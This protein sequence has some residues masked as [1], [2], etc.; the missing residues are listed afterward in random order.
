[1]WTQ[2]D[3][4]QAYQFLRRR[5][6]S[7]LVKADANHP[8]SPSRR[9]VLGTVVGF[10]A[11]L[12]VTAVFGILGVLN[13]N[14][15][16]TWQ[17]GGY[18][19]VEQET[20]ERLVV[21]QDK[22]LHPTLNYTSARLYAGGKGDK[23]VT[24]AAADLA[25][26][27][28]GVTVG[29]PGAPDSIPAANRLYGGGWL[30]CS[31]LPADQPTGA[32]P[33]STV[34]LVA[35]GGDAAALPANR[36]LL[37]AL[38]DGD[39]FLI[40][41]G[42]R[43]RITTAALIA[44]GYQDA[45]PITVAP[46]WVNTVPAGADFDVIGVPGAGAAG[47]RVGDQNTRVGQVLMV[48]T[49]TGSSAYY[50]V[51]SGGLQPIGPVEAAL[52]LADPANGGGQHQQAQSASA[53]DVATAAQVAAANLGAGGYPDVVPSMSGPSGGAQTV[54][55]VND[56]TDT[57]SRTSILLASSVPLPS[58]ST[59][60]SRPVPDGTLIADQVYVPS[61]SGAL[62]RARN[63][64]DPASGTVYLVTDSGMKYPVAG[65]TEL[66]ALGYG[67]APVRGMAEGLLDL[68]PTGPELDA[69]ASHQIVSGGA[70]R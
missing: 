60:I 34:A 33:R 4:I 39:R 27:S 42:Y 46:D 53:T 36:A 19:I 1:V 23:T 51:R 22:M 32:A 8:T 6:V 59:P 28:R 25:G 48:S 58:G 16:N 26:M 21:G 57:G 9:L 17:Q 70:A 67:S 24:V 63:L 2:R 44:L 37:V 12:L 29:I 56:S 61:S 52:I 11:T 20:G 62:V 43:H 18:V 47:T 55:S 45:S 15:G 66:A 3:Q 10:A 69:N 65:S 38:P 41:N 68:L 5:L 30:G 64:G 50:M 31:E 35:P 54:C 14:S 13:P 40:T 49:A 7:A